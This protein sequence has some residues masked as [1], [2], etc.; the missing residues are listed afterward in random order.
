[1]SRRENDVSRFRLTFVKAIGPDRRYHAP[2][3]HRTMPLA[4]SVLLALALVAGGMARGLAQPGAMTF[5]AGLT[6]MVICADGEAATVL[7]DAR[8]NVI[9]PDQPCL[10]HHCD[11]CLLA[12]AVALVSP[13]FGP[14]LRRR[15]IRPAHPEAVLVTLTRHPLRAVARGPPLLKV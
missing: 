10:E 6:E 4:L 5:T 1:M 2:M 14:E 9:D 3:L 8:G 7:V 11:Q 15:A 13:G 12:G